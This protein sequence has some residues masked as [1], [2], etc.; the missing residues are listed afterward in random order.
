M[1]YCVEIV[2]LYVYVPRFLAICAISKLR[3]AFC[4]LP[5]CVPISKLR[6]RFRNCATRLLH[7]LEMEVSEQDTPALD[8]SNHAVNEGERNC[9]EPRE[10][11]DRER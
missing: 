10:T 5:N 9:A 6:T 7:N 1:K 11:D 3:C 4:Q 8:N 2:C